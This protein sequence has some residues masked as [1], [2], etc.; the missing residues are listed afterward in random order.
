MVKV[1]VKL[2]REGASLPQ[3]Q[4]SGAAAFDIQACLSEPLSL[5]PGERKLIPSGL[6][7]AIPEGYEGQLRPRSGM[8]LKKGLGL[9]N[10]PGT[11]DSDFRGELMTLAINLGQ[12]AIQIVHGDRVAQMVISPVIQATIEQVED[13][14]KTDRAEGG[15]GSTG[16]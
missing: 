7:L 5:S 10:S 1:V 16:A 8:A 9:V 3:Y 2:L 13:L 11:I 12:E 14:S 4:T 15:F 6:A